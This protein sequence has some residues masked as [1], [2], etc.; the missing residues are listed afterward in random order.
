MTYGFFEWKVNNH[1]LIPNVSAGNMTLYRGHVA[2]ELRA[3]RPCR[4]G[5]NSMLQNVKPA[6]DVYVFCVTTY[7]EESDLEFGT[8]ESVSLYEGRWKFTSHKGDLMVLDKGFT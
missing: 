7:A 8:W 5:T 1:F 4:R 3:E 2:R 6:T